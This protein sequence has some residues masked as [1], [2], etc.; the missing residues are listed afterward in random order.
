MGQLNFPSNAYLAARGR[1]FV[2]ANFA[3][4][5]MVESLHRLYSELAAEPLPA[6]RDGVKVPE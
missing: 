4:E 1:E 5:Q 2:R 3:V 6:L